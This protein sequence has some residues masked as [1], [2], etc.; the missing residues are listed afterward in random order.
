MLFVS[1]PGN[2]SHLPHKSSLASRYHRFAPRRACQPCQCLAVIPWQPIRWNTLQLVG[3][4]LQIGQIIERI[5]SIQF[6]LMDQTYQQVAHSTAVQNL[7]D[8]Y[9][10]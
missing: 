8:K 2:Q 5:G 1:A 7:V 4:P 10:S 6:A 9:F 3:V